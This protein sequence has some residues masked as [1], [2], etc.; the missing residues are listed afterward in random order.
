MFLPCV[1]MYKFFR[2]VYV[3]HIPYADKVYVDLNEVYSDGLGDDSFTVVITPAMYHKCEEA[4][5]F[6]SDWK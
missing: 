3:N 5:R 2:T 1:E 4:A 6:I